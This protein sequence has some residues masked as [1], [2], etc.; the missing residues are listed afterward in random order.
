MLAEC[1]TQHPKLPPFSKFPNAFRRFYAMNC[2]V[3]HKNWSLVK[4]LLDSFSEYPINDEEYSW[5][6]VDYFSYADD[7]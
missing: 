1:T 5:I 6:E 4:I 3:T 7:W 2:A